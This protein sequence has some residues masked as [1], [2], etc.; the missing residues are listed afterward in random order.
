MVANTYYSNP[1]NEPF[2]DPHPYRSIV[3][4]LQYLKF[5]RHYSLALLTPQWSFMPFQMQTEVVVH[6]WILLLFRWQ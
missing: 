3:G 6:Y 5:T 2:L 1:M 4:G